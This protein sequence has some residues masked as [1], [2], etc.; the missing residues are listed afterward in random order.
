MKRNKDLVEKHAI[1]QSEY[2]NAEA[3]YRQGQASVDQYKA[4]IARK[5]LRAPFDGVAGIRQV[6]LGQYLKEGDAVVTLQAFDPI[7]V[8]FSLPQQ[9]LGKLTVG[10]PVALQVDAYCRSSF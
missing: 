9:D 2:D 8:N 1:S 3:I 10:E 6:N 5:T 4:L 7:Y